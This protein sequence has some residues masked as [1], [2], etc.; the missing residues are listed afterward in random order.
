MKLIIE[1]YTEHAKIKG[2]KKKIRS[3]LK[4]DVWWTSQECLDNRL[5]DAIWE[6][7]DK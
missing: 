5:V 2:G 6:E 7:R 3:V 1:I 4:K